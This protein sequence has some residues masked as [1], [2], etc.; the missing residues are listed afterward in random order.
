MNMRHTKK[1]ALHQ[2]YPS[3]HHLDGAQ[4]RMRSQRRSRSLTRRKAWRQAALQN[5][6]SG[7][8]VVLEN[9]SSQPGRGQEKNFRGSA[10]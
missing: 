9:L 2:K 4:P 1:P 10:F 5:F 3:D 8:R 7:L 6:C